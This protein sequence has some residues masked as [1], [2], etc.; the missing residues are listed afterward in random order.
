MRTLYPSSEIHRA[1]EDNTETM[2]M[3]GLLYLMDTFDAIDESVVECWNGFCKY[4]DGSCESFDRRR[5]MQMFRAQ[6]RV[7]DGCLVGSLFCAPTT[8][9]LPLGKLLETQQADIT[10]TQLWLLNRLWNLCL[11]HGLLRDVSDYAE[12]QY[13]YACHIA[14]DLAKA[15]EGLSLPAMEVHG[16]GLVEKLYDI[17]TG[18]V[19]CISLT[20]ST[21]LE[22]A[23][24][25]R[26]G[27]AIAVVEDYSVLELLQKLETL[28]KHFRG[29][30]HEYAE[31]IGDTLHG[32]P[33]YHNA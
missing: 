2:S 15:C 1:V 4:S 16:V 32:I 5:A 14:R 31:K 24:P 29:G 7:R 33:G 22:S 9:P 11:L 28:I 10:I 17:A 6:H 13:I 3:T 23:V 21:S 19:T 12:L 25:C 18:V 30:G 26:T 8:N 27:D 20:S